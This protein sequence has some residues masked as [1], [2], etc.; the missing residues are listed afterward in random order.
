MQE[1]FNVNT[2]CRYLTLKD[3]LLFFNRLP[4]LE[5]RKFLFKFQFDLLPVKIKPYTTCYQYLFLKHESDSVL[6][7]FLIAF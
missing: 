6:H 3:A 1:K 5:H 4:N 2:V 7:V